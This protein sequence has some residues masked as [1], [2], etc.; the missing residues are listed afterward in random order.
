MLTSSLI[1][2]RSRI[3]YTFDLSQALVTDN[4]TL[5]Q[6]I[7]MGFVGSRDPSQ[8]LKLTA[9]CLE[10]GKPTRR[11]LQGFYPSGETGRGS[12]VDP[13]D[14]VTPGTWHPGIQEKAGGAGAWVVA[15]FGSIV[16]ALKTTLSSRRVRRVLQ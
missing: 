13:R 3:K 15:Q 6:N 1:Y 5:L 12:G 2:V 4:M 10:S 7:G 14:D 8:Q 16:P 11:G 9:G